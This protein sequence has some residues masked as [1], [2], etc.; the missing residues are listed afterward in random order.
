MRL[1]RALLRICFSILVTTALPATEAQTISPDVTAH[2]SDFVVIGGPSSLSFRGEPITFYGA[3]FYP[4]P[5]GGS[6][7]WHRTDFKTY[8]DQVLAMSAAAGQNMIRP[9]DYWDKHA[10]SQTM[11]DPVLWANMDYLLAAA[12]ARGMFVLMDLSAYKWLLMS[13]GKDWLTAE[14][15]KP[16]LDFVAKRY[17]DD[18]TVAFWSIVGEPSV[19]KS[20]S[21]ADNMVS[22]YDALT[23]YLK[24][25]DPHHLVC[26]GGF[27]HMRDGRQFRWWERIY[28]L[29]ANDI[30]AFKT[31]SQHDLDLIPA[32]GEFSRSIGKP[33]IDQ[34]FGLPQN[35]GDGVW[36]GKDYNQLHL[37]RAAFFKE[38]Y[39]A[40]LREGVVGFQFW[41]LG[42][43]VKPGSYEISPAFP[44]V[45]SV[46]R[47][48]S[49]AMRSSSQPADRNSSSKTPKAGS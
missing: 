9:T 41:N 2:R 34:E 4:A 8:I 32:I 1:T 39:E 35:M 10:P 36:S 6:S 40:G 26:A 22:F 29:P 30:V 23:R 11:D 45:W 31:Y 13:Q 15:W 5:V 24:H 14:S 28:L 25:A 33:A 43:E 37:S 18:P 19:P 27:N 49:S 17:G 44:A 3:T 47:Q 16:F 42:T 12:K 48:F 7:A 38:V 20:Q 46:I 21:E